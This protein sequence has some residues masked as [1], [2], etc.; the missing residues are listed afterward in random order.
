MGFCCIFAEK[1]RIM[2]RFA[3]I[4]VIG[5][6]LLG[7]VGTASAQ[8]TYELPNMKGRMVYGGNFGFGISGNY[9]NF[10][11]APQIG[12]RIFHP[13]EVGVRGIYTLQCHFDRYQ[14]NEYGHYFGVAPYTNVEIFGNVFLHVE[15]EVMYGITRWNHSSVASQW[16]NS[17]FVGGGYRQYAYNGSFVYFMVLYNLSWGVV[18]TGHWDTPYGSPLSIR[19]GYCF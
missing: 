6:M 3:I 17:I 8:G 9:L 16:Y 10:S 14:G 7:L 5:M 1:S 18:Q 15:D 12:Y 19:V 4:T 2:K 11:L 13:W